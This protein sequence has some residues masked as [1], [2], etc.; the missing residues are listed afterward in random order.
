MLSGLRRFIVPS[1][2]VLGAL[3]ALPSVARADERGARAPVVVH[4]SEHDRVRFERERIERE[5]IE[6]ERHHRVVCERAY[7]SG[8]SWWRL[9]EMGC[10]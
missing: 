7:E 5:R 9:R 8:A 10:R 6:R 4:V 2:A 1:L 3:V